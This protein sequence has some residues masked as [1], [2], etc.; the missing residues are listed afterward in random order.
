MPTAAS[1]PKNEITIVGAGIVGLATAFHLLAEGHRVRLVERGGVAEGASFGNAGAF[2]FSDILPLASPGMLRKAPKWLIDPLGPLTIPPRYL[3]Q[4]TPWL[5][6]FWRASLPDRYRASLTAQG[7][8]MRFAAT[9]TQAM[10]A[11][12]D[13]AGHIRADGNLQLYESEAELAAAQPG[14]EARARE[15]IEF[16]HV[17]G[18]RLAELQPGLSPRFVAGTFTPHWQTV[19]DPY[20]YALA[21]FRAVMAR[22]AGLV[23]GEVT[24]VEADSRGV[25]LRLADGQVLNAGRVVI[26]GGAWSRPLARSLGDF[27]PLETERG[28]NTTLPPG[29]FD[30]RRQLTFGGH[31]FVVTPLSTGIR[32]GGAVE[33]GGLKAPPNFRRADAMLTKAARFLP[34]LRTEGG[35]QWMG[36]RPSLPDSLPV[37]GR[38]TAS[39]AAFYAFGHGHLGLTQSAATGKLIADLVAG[40]RPPIPLEPFR[41]D[42]F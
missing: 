1:S 40:R 21:L 28:Y 26:A 9:A 17:R 31:G 5:V 27:I 13:L 25:R 30:L 6:R 10:V 18:E 35:R 34:G 36:F 23:H 39:P 29:A 24:G 41:P 15:G 11:Q 8:L 7:G 4:I 22:G 2:A 37:I 38:S 32:V 19:S 3:P 33:L 16:E 14:W 12:A 42:R 20:H